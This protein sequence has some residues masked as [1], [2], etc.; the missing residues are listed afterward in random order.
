M[1]K[2]VLKRQYTLSD[3]IQDIA[4]LVSIYFKRQQKIVIGIAPF[5]PDLLILMKLMH[6]H[7]VFYHTSFT[8]W[9]GIKMPYPAKSEK[10]LDKWMQFTQVYVKHIF[11]VS[12]KTK[13][14]LIKFKFACD[15]RISVV[16]HSYNIPIIA[17]N[18]NCKKN[19]FIYVGRIV[20]AKG[21]KEL[22]DIFKNRPYA[23]LI[24]IGEG[25]EAN[26]VKKYTMQFANILYKGYINGL[27]KI[28][29]YYKESCFLVLNSKRTGCWEELFGITIIEG[30]ACGCVPIVTDHSGPLEIIKPLKNGIICKECEIANGIDYAISM[31]DEE[32]INMRNGAIERAKDFYSKNAAKRWNKIFDDY[33]K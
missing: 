18:V 5:N 27:S 21:I 12:T 1:L 20:E 3:W 13:S 16:Y 17:P 25:D 29:P 30:M 2:R 7:D 23:R 6:R 9:N 10:Y 15:N 31:T 22:L 33:N 32:Y 14:E 24:I 11:A 26:I 4:S 28:L 8:R 19:T